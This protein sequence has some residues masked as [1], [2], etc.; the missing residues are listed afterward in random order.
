MKRII[1]SPTRILQIALVGLALVLLYYTAEK[2]YLIFHS[3][4]ELFSIGVIYSLLILAWNTRRFHENGFL[5]FVAL[6]LLFTSNIDLVHTLSYRGMNLLPIG[7]NPNIPTQLWIAARYMQAI[8]LLIAP[9]YLRRKI[10]P[11]LVI[12]LFSFIDLL[13]L[14]SIFWWRIFPICYIDGIGQTPFKIISEY[15]IIL[16]YLLAILHFY[17]RRD[18]VDSRIYDYMIAMLAVSIISEAAFTGYVSVY[19]FAN[20]LGHILK[21]LAFYLVYKAIVETGLNQPVE[22]L[23]HNLQQ[24]QLALKKAHDELEIRVIERT[25]ELQSEIQERKKAEEKLQ[26]HANRM[27]TLASVSQLLFEFAPGDT[28]LIGKIAANLSANVGDCCVIRLL[29][30]DR[31]RLEAVAIHHRD[32]QN[33]NLMEEVFSDIYGI[34]GKD[35][36]G[37]I[38]SEGRTVIFNEFPMDL[39]LDSYGEDLR[40]K[41]ETLGFSSVMISS[42]QVGGDKF[43]TLTLF[44]TGSRSIYTEEDKVLIEAIADRLGLLLNNSRLYENLQKSLAEEQNMRQRLIQAEKHS[45][46]SRMIAS[47]AH[48]LNNPVQTIQNCLYLFKQHIGPEDPF[49]PYV[50]MAAKETER[51]ANLVNQLREVYRPKRE[52]SKEIVDIDRLLSDVYILLEPHLSRNHVD[53]INLCT[54]TDSFRLN[55]VPDQIKQVF[56][57]LGLNAIEAMQPEGGVIYLDKQISSDG[58]LL[59]TSILDTG[60]GIPIENQTKIFEPFFTTKETGNGLGLAICYDIVLRHGGTIAIDS[61]PGRGAKFTVWLPLDQGLEPEPGARRLN[62]NK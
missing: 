20:W 28:T 2:Y 25:A 49:Q 30:E 59:G 53:W 51:I 7:D 34:P 18:E 35:L 52:Q 9:V 56:L 38:F 54:C 4:A 45:V 62:I 47:I 15:I 50:G 26:A 1:S 6:A 19:S 22:L 43:G 55:L 23:F 3:F 57:N 24:G 60:P 11:G 8:G 27:E 14:A 61:Q 10:N 58:C 37:Q 13:V 16:I 36:V 32:A 17:R 46:I 29:S 42:M 48:E 12:S 39:F 31:C 21:I 41:I 40:P 44:R 5:L 33:Q